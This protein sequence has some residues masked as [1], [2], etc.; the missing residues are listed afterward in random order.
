MAKF[1]SNLVQFWPKLVIFEFESK[2]WN[3]HLLSTPESRIKTKKL[4]NS[5]VQFFRKIP[6][7]LRFWAFGA[8]K[9]NFR[10]FWAKMAKMVKIIKKAFEHFFRLSEF[11]LTEMYQEKVMKELRG[12]LGLTDKRLNDIARYGQIWVNFGQNG[13]FLNLSRKSET[14]ICFQLQRRGLKQRIS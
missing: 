13:S 5:N 1:R 8:T 9:A 6:K 2:K 12:R 4:E 3:H 11:S 14:V 7:N 10:Q